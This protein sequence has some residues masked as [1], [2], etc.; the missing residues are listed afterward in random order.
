M[1][2]DLLPPDTG[3]GGDKGDKAP[4]QVTCEFCGCK[5]TRH[6]EIVKLGEDAKRMRKAEQ[7]IEELTEQAGRLQSAG[8]AYQRE[9]ET[10]RAEV[11]ELRAGRGGGGKL[12]GWGDRT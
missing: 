9:A 2:D 3:G 1:A 5:L 7:T 11:K 10:L 6:G 4:R 8:E 12:D